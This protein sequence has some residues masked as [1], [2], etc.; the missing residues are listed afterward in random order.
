MAVNNACCFYGRLFAFLPNAYQ[1]DLVQES[2]L[3][4]AGLLS[5]QP[6]FAHDEKS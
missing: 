6:I 3:R 2:L 5:R 4:Q 1:I